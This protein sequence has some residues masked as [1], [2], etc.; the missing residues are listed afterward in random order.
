VQ[1]IAEWIIIDL[2]QVP[3]IRCQTSGAGL[4]V[5]DIA[6]MRNASSSPQR[7]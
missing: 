2:H 5:A 4:E 7:F 6:L 3:A 1:A